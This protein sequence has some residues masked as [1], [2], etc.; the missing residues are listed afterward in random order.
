[1]PATTRT[2]NP[3]AFLRRLQSPVGLLELTSDGKAITTLAIARAGRVPR[4]DEPERSVA[5]LER[6]ATQLTEYFDGRRKHFTLRTAVEGTEFQQ[7]V[8]DGLSAVVWGSATTYG[9]LGAVA[10]RPGAGRATG[11]AVRA[12]PIPIIVPCHR[13]LALNGHI[14]GYSWGDGIETKAWLLE[15]EGIPHKR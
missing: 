9:A 1:M 2:T 14:T 12:N 8:W 4:H 13:V 15:H 3:A 10:G 6:A 5:V 7:R 11:A